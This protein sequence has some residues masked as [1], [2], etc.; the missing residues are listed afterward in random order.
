MRIMSRFRTL[1]CLLAIFILA[2]VVGGCQSKQPEVSQ[3]LYTT[4]PVSRGDVISTVYASG[5]LVL[6]DTVK[7]ISPLDS[8]LLD[9]LVKPGTKVKKGDVLARLDKTPFE[10]AYQDAIDKA[11][12]DLESV[13]QTLR[14]TEDN[15]AQAEYGVKQA[16]YNVKQA[17][18]S[19]TSAESS[20]TQAQYNLQLAQYNYQQAANSNNTTAQ[21]SYQ[22]WIAVQIATQAVNGAEDGVQVAE[23][24]V[25]FAQEGVTAANS[26]A[27]SARQEVNA[28]SNKVDV[29][30]EALKHA[31]E[32][33]SIL[34]ASEIRAPSDGV[35]MDIKLNEGDNVIK[36][37]PIIVLADLNRIELMVTV[38]QD[39]IMSVEPA[40]TADISLDALPGTTLKGKVDYI[41]PT[42]SASSN[43]PTYEIFLSLDDATQGLLPGM[44]GG[45]TILTAEKHG[46]LRVLRRLVKLAPDGSGQVEV[47]E[48]GQPVTKT[49]VIGLKGDNY[50]EI[51]SGLNEGE[52]V[53]QRGSY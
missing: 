7:L 18:H 26:K 8:K 23:G 52:L 53:V 11:E 29:A 34:D 9:L 49:V 31:Q 41:V 5:E 19:R 33:K 3:P 2:G 40:M 39:S 36:D 1:G 35:V 17:E 51:L 30:E 50:Y 20:L 27:E 10:K 46:V 24:A 16:E 38:P 4:T 37:S 42:K 45:A 43:T 25:A 13:N 6:T 28:A 32:D 15:L 14:S 48:Q 12:T 47:L 21:Q 44:T 22:N